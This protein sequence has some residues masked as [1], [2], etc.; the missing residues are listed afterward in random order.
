[1]DAGLRAKGRDEPSISIGSMFAQRLLARLDCFALHSSLT[2]KACVP[3]HWSHDDRV[4]GL[5][6]AEQSREN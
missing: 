4:L 2:V 3:V 1:M 5:G 6:R